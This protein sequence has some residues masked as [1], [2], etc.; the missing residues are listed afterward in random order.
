MAVIR[1]P[2]YKLNLI[3]YLAHAS[4]K[5]VIVSILREETLSSVFF[6]LISVTS[7]SLQS[8]LRHFQK[9]WL[10]IMIMWYPHNVSPCFH[11]FI[12]V[13]SLSSSSFVS[14]RLAVISHGVLP[15][16]S[17]SNQEVAEKQNLLSFGSV[18]FNSVLRHH[19]SAV[20]QNVALLGA[21]WFH[22]YMNTNTVC[23]MLCYQCRAT[24]HTAAAPQNRTNL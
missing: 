22:P 17:C 9:L 12:S 11:V 18:Q 3:S 6:S 10:F 15:L 23:S 4:F 14:R 7:S 8:C 16:L 1:P 24:V 13:F 21:R 20:A 2:Q 5:Q 19:I